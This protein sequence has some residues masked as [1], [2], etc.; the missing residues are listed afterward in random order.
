M[1]YNIAQQW[2]KR[3]DMYTGLSEEAAWELHL[4]EIEQRFSFGLAPER[5]LAYVQRRLD[6]AHNSMGGSHG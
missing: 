1:A 4:R 6:E 3:V 5:E 2:Q